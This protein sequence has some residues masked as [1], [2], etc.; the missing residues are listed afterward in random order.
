MNVKTETK[1]RTI[2]QMMFDIMERKNKISLLISDII[3]QSSVDCIQNTRD[4]F[5]INEKCLRFSEKLKDEDA[6]FPGITPE[7]LN[8]I[9]NKQLKTSFIFKVNDKT[10]VISARSNNDYIYIYYQFNVSQSDEPDIRYVRENATRICDID[11]NKKKIYF[12]ENKKHPY[13]KKLGVKFSVFQTSYKINENY[14]DD[15]LNEIFPE[16]EYLIDENYIHG[17]VVKYNV[18]E[19][20]FYKFYNDK[21]IRL[22]DLK[23]I[24]ATNYDKDI[25]CIIIHNGKFYLSN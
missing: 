20:L 6:F 24:E 4:E 19:K 18:T 10:F 13:N 8:N 2:D 12:Y 11:L 7:T 9:D 5:S 14:L 3:K 23:S 15:L 22:Y 21:I 16:I 1:D 25:E 17:Y